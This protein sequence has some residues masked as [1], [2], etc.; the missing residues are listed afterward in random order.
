MDSCLFLCPECKVE[1]VP[2]PDDRNVARCPQCAKRFN[3][4]SMATLRESSDDGFFISLFRAILCVIGIFMLLI[5]VA[6]AGCMLTG[7]FDL[8]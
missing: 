8:R 2:I 6:F 3:F 4:K 7:G 1:L 5:A